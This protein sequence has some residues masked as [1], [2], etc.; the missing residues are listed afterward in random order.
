M[1][2]HSPADSRQ[3]NYSHSAARGN[4]TE[5]ATMIPLS[6]STEKSFLRTAITPAL[7]VLAIL[8]V[9]VLLV[10]ALPAA[11]ALAAATTPLPG[12]ELRVLGI[13]DEPNADSK[14]PEE[15]QEEKPVVETDEE[16]FFNSDYYY[17]K[18]EDEE[19]HGDYY[20]SDSI[21]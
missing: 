21:N 10:L 5:E 13:G 8:L 9:Q 17:P 12:Q 19:E 7:A 6:L 14:Q 18:E 3:R 11:P 16:K 15:E 4:I 1:R 20:D 2:S